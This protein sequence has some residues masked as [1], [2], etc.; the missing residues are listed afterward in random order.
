M[1]LSDR[2]PRDRG[3]RVHLVASPH[4]TPDLGVDDGVAIVFD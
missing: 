3:C 1:P 4:L 2:A